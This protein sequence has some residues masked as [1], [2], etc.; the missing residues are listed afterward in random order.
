MGQLP[1][2]LNATLAAWSE[3]LSQLWLQFFPRWGDREYKIVMVGL[4]NAGK[5]TILY[6]LHLGEAVRTVPTIGSNVEQVKVSKHITFEIWD[7]AGQANLRPSWSNYY[8][9]TNAIIVV[10][11]STDRARIGI[12]KQELFKQ[13]QH[14]HLSNACVLIYANKQDLNGAMTVPELSEGLDLI[15]LKSHNWHVQASCALT[16]EGLLEGLQWVAEELRRKEAAPHAQPLPPPGPP[17]QPAGAAAQQP[18][19]A[20]PQ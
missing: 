3:S 10:A 9:A 11:D 1:S 2:T 12:L 4:D 20:P 7:L 18:A 6:R 5:T 14:E 15:S 13:L 16:G 8:Q 17:Q 19:A